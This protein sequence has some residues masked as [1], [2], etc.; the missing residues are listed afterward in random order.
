MK[1]VLASGNKGKAAEFARFFANVSSGPEII[2]ASEIDGAL[3]ILASTAEDG[4]TY[5]EN[6][7]I[8]ASALAKALSMPAIADDSGLEV[9]ALGWG[10]GI[11]SARYCEGSDDDRM[12]RMLE[13][14]RDVSG[15]GRDARFVSCIVI[16]FPNSNGYFSSRGSCAGRISN[17]KRGKDGFGYDPIFV[18][19]GME[20][21]FAEL[22]SDIK[23]KISHRTSALEGMAKM[24]SSV[25]KYNSL[26]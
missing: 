26:L 15:E 7:L 2:S 16:A 23:E 20:L 10:P 19:E 22:G 12:D 25:I 11:K 4:S 5:E 17:A 8:K 13:E 14:L 18:P 3:D 6:A 21:T 9:R 1:A 24:M